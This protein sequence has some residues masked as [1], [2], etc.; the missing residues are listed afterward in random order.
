MRS[1]ASQNASRTA[2]IIA[3]GVAVSACG[4]PAKDTYRASV[5]CAANEHVFHDFLDQQYDPLHMAPAER[6][7]MV[8]FNGTALRLG[9]AL[10]YSEGQVR[11]DALDLIALRGAEAGKIDFAIGA[12][13]GFK[14]SET[15]QKRFGVAAGRPAYRFETPASR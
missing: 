3:I 12:A 15:C 8:A 2:W 11:R 4:N 1:S 7:R 5:E 13:S 6:S 10:G 9:R 14:F